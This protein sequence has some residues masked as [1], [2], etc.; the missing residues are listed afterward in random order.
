MTRIEALK[1]YIIDVLE[2]IL[3]DDTFKM[4]IDFLSNEINSY[5][6]DKIPT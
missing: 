4:N 6:I 5:S 1:N 3:T 2:D